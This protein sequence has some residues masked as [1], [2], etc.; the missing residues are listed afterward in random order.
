MEEVKNITVNFRL[1]KNTYAEEN[2][3]VGKLMGGTFQNPT[4]KK[5][6][7]T[8]VKLTNERMMVI[9]VDIGH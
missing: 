7:K 2:L 3:I 1:K 6:Y 8:S 5:E 4:Q 9:A